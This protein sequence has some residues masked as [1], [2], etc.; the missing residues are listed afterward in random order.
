MGCTTSA[1]VFDGLR[2]VLER[3]CSG[4]ICKE[5][6]EPAGPSEAERAL[7][8]RE[9][10]IIPTPRILKVKP[11]VI[12]PLDYENVLVQRKTQILSDV[13]RDMLQF[14][15]ED[16]EI[17][18]LRR[19]GRTLYPTVPENAE[20]E[21]QSLFVQ[22]CIKTYKS[23]WHV[24]NYKYEDYS[25]DFRQLP[26]KVPRPEKLAV[27]VFEVD[28][29]VDKEEDT[30]SLGSQK[31]GIS[32]HGWLYKGNMNSAISV[33][34]RSFKRRYFHLTQLGDGSY[35]LNFYKDEKISK[36]PKGTIFLDSCMGV[37]QNNKVRRFAFELKM[38]DKSTYLLAAESEAEMED[39]INMLNK[40]L[41]SSFEI[42]M[43]EKRN[44][45]IHDDDDLGKSDSSSGSLDS[46]QSTRD[47]ESRMRSETRLKLFTVDPDTQKLDFSGIEPDV[48]QFE[49]KFG[50][51]VLVNCNDLSFN[52]QSCVAENEEGPTTNVEPFYVTLSLFDIQN[53]RKISSD[54][55]VDL[56]HQSVRGMVPS[57]ASQYVNGG[58]EARSEGQRFIHGVPESALL[59]PKQGVFSVTCPHPDIFLVA[60]I[61]KVLQGGINHCAEPYMKSSDSTKMAQKVL[62][63]AKLACSRLGQYRM[64]F[65]WAARL[66]FKDASGTLDKSARFS[67]LYRQDSNKLSND[68]MLKLLADFRKP[69]K[70]AKL[71]IILGNLDVTIDS[72]APDLTNCVTSS[73]IPVKQFDVSERSRVFFEVEEFV[74][75]IAKCSQPFTIYNNHLYVYPKHLKYDSQ[76][77]FAKA[78][79]IAVCIEFRDS[80]DE[81]AVSLKCIYGRPGGPL[82]TKNAFTSVLHHQHNPEFYDEFKIELPTQLHEKHHLLFTFYHV[83]CDSNSKASTKKKD[84]VET[85]VGY[86]WLPLLKDGRVIMNEHHIPVAANLPAGYLS[87]Q[88]GAS[89]HLSPE[90]KWVDG[91]KHLFKVSTHLVSTVYTQDQ[92]LHNFFHHCQSV[93]SAAQGPGG[94]L[95]KYLKSLHAMESHVMIKFLPTILNQLFRVLTSATQEDVAVN[96]TRVMIHVVAQCHEE[97]LEHYLR[98]YV[99]FVFRTESY[100]SSTTRTVHEELAKAMTV[101]LKPSTDFLTSNK[102]LKYS[103]YFFEALVKSM[104][105]YLIES[106]K[107]RLSRNQRFSASFHHTVET[108]VN[109][110]MPHITQKYKDNLDAARNANH[111]LAV[112][113]K[114]CFNLMDRGFVFKQINNYI[115]GF[116]PGDPKTLFEFKFEFLRVVCNH[117][118][119][120]PLNLPM[121]FGKGRIL[122]FQ[123]ETVESDDTPVD[124]QM[125]YS[126]T[127]D[128]CRNHFLVGLLL[129]EVSTALQE[130]REIRQIAIQVLK[131]LMI[132]HTFDDRYSSKSQQARLATL[133]FPLFGLL[134]ENVNRLNVKEV[135][136]FPVNHSNNNGR[137]DS[138]LSNA[139]MTPPRSSTFLDTSLHKDVFGAISGTT[140]PHAVSTPNVN[141]MRHTDSRGSLISTESV[142]SL[143]E[144]NHDK[145][146]SLDKNQPA[147][148]LGSTLMRCDKLDQAEI[149]S[150]LMCFLHVLK[151]MSE[152]ALFTYWNKASSAELM[153][154]FILIEVCL[155]QFR[156]MGK[157][158]IASVRKISSIL[159]ISVEHAYSHS[160]AD[161]LNQSLLEANIATEVCLTVLD[162][163]SIFIMGFKTQL[164][165]DH[166]HSPLMKKVFEVHLCF[167]RINQSETALKQVFTSLR[168][169]IYKFPCTFFEGRADMCAAFCYE[170]LKCCNSK[171]SSIRSDAAHLLYFLMK[172]NFDYTGRKSFVRTHLQVVIAVSQLIADVIGIGSTRFQHSLSIINNCA[173]SDRTI[174][175]TAFPSDVKDLTKRIRTV[176]M[177]TAQMKE[178]ERDPE[179]LVDLQYS[180]AKSY[181]STPELRKTWLDS[182]ARIHVKNGDLSE[183]AMCYVHVAALV[184][185][186]LRR[187]GASVVSDENAF[188]PVLLFAIRK[189]LLVLTSLLLSYVGMFKQG[190]SAFRVVTPNIDEEAAM[191]ED[192]GMQD[193]H[194]N[195]DV[196][197]ELL[198]ECADGLWKAERY[199]LISDIYK[200]IIPIYEK[201][202]DFEKLAHLYDTLH[203]AY[204][205]VTEVMHTGKRL[206]GTYFRVAF[207]GQGFFED[208]DGKEYIYKEPKFTPLS[209]IS[210]RLLKLYSD[211]F[212]QEN[213]KMI[214]DSGRINP[215]DLDSKY[216]YIQVTHV[217]PY[218][219]EKE[220]ADRKTEFEKSHNIRRFVFEMP[221][222][223][224]GKKQGGVEEQCKRRTI[225]TTTHCFPYVKK[226]I[227]VMYQHH[228]DLSPIEVAIDEMSKKVA[229]INQLCS[230]S[231]VDMIRLQLKLQGSISVQVNAGPLAYARAFLDDSSAKKYPDNK[232]KQLKEVFRH[233]VEA[234]GHGLGINERLIKEDQQEYH[235][236]MKANYRDLTRELSIIMHEQIIPVDDGMKSVLPDSLHIFNAISGTPTSVTIQG[237]PHSASV[238]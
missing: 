135:S 189:I 14:P 80:D 19:H 200:L 86:A 167:L 18:T 125:D 220:L 142:N 93:A 53:G 35:N 158:Y 77:S 174:K 121:P 123:D 10:R 173:N 50:K 67:A 55:Q 162:T 192:V 9:S 184:A 48:K 199:E 69:E 17:S 102:L 30:A 169:F 105:Q 214:Q 203:R 29:D 114:R 72:V 204:S 166:G 45:D 25:G 38:Q 180:L 61:D 185:E 233:F 197:M 227:A 146:N 128:F 139:L 23:D 26:N 52:L 36:E 215:K 156:Y 207:F 98:S 5:A 179:M 100:T 208:E 229:E 6:A 60:R 206:L 54:F 161:V 44:G 87:C 216:A 57:N 232:V 136:P 218:L 97:G 103:W 124:L 183:A 96:V 117:E 32:K 49:E 84:V 47:I 144:R 210:Q 213:V 112:F 159:G 22:E 157:R 109:M 149:K 8:R 201:R 182:M 56:N 212:G 175:H 27:H 108:L 181:A 39:W 190:C 209:E 42:A 148:T 127:E 21:A 74:P 228:T 224:S 51:R 75:F 132:K 81:E 138:L 110:M 221:F 236:E 82:F 65:A 66:L 152:D 101:I 4:Y 95:V 237:I 116:M 163:L 91:G 58:G 168:T 34:M 171:L 153:D 111:S 59:Y 79:N 238:I 113:I 78:R 15:L 151:S 2:T 64:P 99:K 187:K 219:D 118:H 43:Q 7:S 235:D 1:V 141:S 188:D 24:V 28:E 131:C 202:R 63:N 126:L 137:D 37:V 231:D 226:R 13:L 46:F 140:S 62:K 133:Y 40:I 217:T 154:F 16:F 106:C 172:S 145:T 90:V 143:H 150:L 211:K 164:C 12:E 76:K 71:P 119:Y 70:M 115:N 129:R 196:L 205:K 222:T 223:I 73:Y 68:D 234:C 31:G 94:E 120:V 107:V 33:T 41:H 130:F 195:E 230:S 198:E 20:R 194:F 122:R 170:I 104:A 134:Q 165:S 147:S 85:Q 176:L 191:M 88:E 193:V 155:H 177:A 186:Y 89:K 83:S 225:L 160:D 3:N 178:H 92:H 11:K